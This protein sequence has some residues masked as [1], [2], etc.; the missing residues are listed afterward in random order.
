MLVCSIT[1]FSAV[2]IEFLSPNIVAFLVLINDTSV[3]P[4][5]I[6]ESSDDRTATLTESAP[7]VILSPLT[8]EFLTFD[9]NTLSVPT[10]IALSTPCPIEPPSCVPIIAPAAS[11]TSTVPTMFCSL[12]AFR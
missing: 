4:D 8:T 9:S 1:Q 6:V 10:T 5:L 11:S 2:I 7:M 3:E 12:S